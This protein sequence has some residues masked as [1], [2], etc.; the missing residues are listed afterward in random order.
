MTFYQLSQSRGGRDCLE[1]V[2]KGAERRVNSVTEQE[3][4]LYNFLLWLGISLYS[5]VYRPKKSSLSFTC[6]FSR[7]TTPELKTE[8]QQGESLQVWQAFRSTVEQVLTGGRLTAPGLVSH[9]AF[10]NGMGSNLGSG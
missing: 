9:K 6:L 1:E 4:A 10:T 7:G 3:W 5:R 2:E 8:E